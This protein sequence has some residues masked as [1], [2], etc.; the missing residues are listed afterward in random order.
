MCKVMHRIG[1][2][3]L[4]VTWIAGAKKCLKYIWTLIARCGL[5]DK[6][7][8]ESGLAFVCILHLYRTIYD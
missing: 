5:R 4:I 8:T 7:G 6:A 3:G 1:A 2:V